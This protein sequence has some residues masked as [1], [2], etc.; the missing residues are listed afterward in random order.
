LRLGS[1]RHLEIDSEEEVRGGV[2]LEARAAEGGGVFEGE[3]MVEARMMGS[4]PIDVA[5]LAQGVASLTPPGCH[6][7][8]SAT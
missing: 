5:M 2:L 8:Y 1:E 4:Y 6:S 3:H 7:T